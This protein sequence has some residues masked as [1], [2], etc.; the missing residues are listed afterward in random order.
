MN[1]KYIFYLVVFFLVYVFVLVPYW[2][3]KYECYYESPAESTSL[4]DNTKLIYLSESLQD[5]IIDEIRKKNSLDV[6]LLINKAKYSSFVTD[7]RSNNLGTEKKI[8]DIS[9]YLEKKS[10]KIISRNKDTYVYEVDVYLC[11]SIT[12]YNYLYP[13]I[14]YCNIYQI[15]TKSRMYT[16]ISPKVFS[17]IYKVN[18]PSPLSAQA[19]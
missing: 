6:S 12:T 5:S 15:K 18:I 16:E 19:E 10:L 2:T 11:L 1:N 4:P 3:S 8:I 9:H 7:S 14:D 13:F 17:E